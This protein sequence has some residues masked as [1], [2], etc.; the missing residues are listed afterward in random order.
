MRAGRKKLVWAS[1]IAAIGL[2]ATLRWVLVPYR[3]TGPSMEP[4]LLA[5]GDIVLVNRLAYLRRGPERWDVVVIEREG[6][7]NI[8]RVVALPGETLEI[9]D[10]GILV[11]GSPL[12]LPVALRARAI[13]SKEAFG[14]GPVHLGGSEY[15][16]LGDGGY[17]SRD[18][19]AW[20]PI[21]STDF[22]GKAVAILWPW[23]RLGALE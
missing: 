3:V 22:R 6:R 21:E 16:L 10:G 1:F 4:T 5:A 23:A 11:N 15:F 12:D 18:S 17:V 14:R 9:R 13:V 2:L 19:R 7:D 8:K 20:G